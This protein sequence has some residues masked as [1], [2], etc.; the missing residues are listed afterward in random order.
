MQRFQVPSVL[1]VTAT[2]AFAGGP[3]ERLR[4]RKVLEAVLS[5]AMDPANPL[6]GSG[7]AG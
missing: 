3:Q 1:L 2:L 5:D 6:N 7:A 4:D